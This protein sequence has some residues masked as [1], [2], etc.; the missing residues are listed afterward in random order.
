[1]SPL[2]KRGAVRIEELQVDQDA[3]TPDFL[4]DHTNRSNATTVAAEDDVVANVA[5]MAGRSLTAERIR[6]KPALTLPMQQTFYEMSANVRADH[7]VCDLSGH[8]RSLAN[9][10][11][12]LRRQTRIQESAYQIVP[13][14]PIGLEVFRT[15]STV[16]QLSDAIVDVRER[17]TDLRSRLRNLQEIL[18]DP[19]IGLDRKLKLRA[20]WMSAWKRLN[21]K[22]EF[23]GAVGLADT[24]NAIY[25][26][27][28]EVPGAMGLNPSSWIKLLKVAVEEW[29]ELWSRWRMRALHRTLRSYVKAPDRDLSESVEKIIRRPI[30]HEEIS[31]V[32]D[33]QQMMSELG[34][35]A[36]AVYFSE[37]P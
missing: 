27:A 18:D 19:S 31:D 25:K 20:K 34:Q 37:S 24:N 15:A 28:P 4:K 7:S 26:L 32:R 29:P 5:V 13:L 10:L 11:D 3:K 22:Y 6:S 23:T 1:M 30:L 9:A 17:F 36:V 2:I 8:Y 14:P 35:S 12:E 16:E 21:T 33:V